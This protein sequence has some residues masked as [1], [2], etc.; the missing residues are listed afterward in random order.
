LYNNFP[1]NQ[2]GFL[3]S[4]PIVKAGDKVVHDTPLTETNYSVNN[5]LAL[6]KNLAVAYMP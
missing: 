4:T 5:T 6:G 3:H 2:D 1:L